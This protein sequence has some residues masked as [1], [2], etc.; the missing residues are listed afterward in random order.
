[1]G[2]MLA[3]VDDDVVFSGNHAGGWSV[4]GKDGVA[5]WMAWVR[6]VRQWQGP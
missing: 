5:K 3:L 2:P 4:K 6:Q 1:M